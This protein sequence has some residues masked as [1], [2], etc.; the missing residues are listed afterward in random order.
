MK[1]A[2]KWLTVSVFLAGITLALVRYYWPQAV[3]AVPFL[4][5]FGGNMFTGFFTLGGFL[6]AMKNLVVLRLQE[7]VYDN[8]EYRAVFERETSKGAR[9]YDPLVNLT[10][11]LVCSVGACLVASILGVAGAF[12]KHATLAEVALAFAAGTISLVFKCWWEMHCNFR[13]YFSRLEEAY[14]VKRVELEMERAR[15]RDGVS[16]T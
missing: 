10:G 9:L 16:G 12:A 3:F 4:T 7:K 11:L 1:S 8:P 15:K 13:I 14:Q 2:L 5:L 6:L